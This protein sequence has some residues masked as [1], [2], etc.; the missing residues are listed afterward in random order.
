MQGKCK[1]AFTSSNILRLHIER[2]HE[3]P[4]RRVKKGSGQGRPA[5][6]RTVGKNKFV[7]GTVGKG[8]AS[9]IR[10]IVC[11]VYIFSTFGINIMP[12]SFAISEQFFANIN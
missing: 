7:K 5:G 3:N 10:V 2:V 9:I 4:R 12:K 11:A 6:W 1:K 8:L